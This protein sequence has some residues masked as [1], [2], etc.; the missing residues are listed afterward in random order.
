MTPY[1]RMSALPHQRVTLDGFDDEEVQESL[2]SRL[3]EL[4]AGLGGHG[5]DRAESHH[6]L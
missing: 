4:K 2:V 3:A 6:P 1:Q 5:S